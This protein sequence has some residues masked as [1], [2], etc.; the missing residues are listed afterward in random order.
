[1]TVHCPS[2]RKDV[3]LSQSECDLPEAT[4]PRSPYVTDKSQFLGSDF[5]PSPLPDDLTE[6]LLAAVLLAPNI[7]LSQGLDF[8]VGGATDC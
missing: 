1:M 3:Q 2:V 6:S 8:C 7:R 4:R 5:W